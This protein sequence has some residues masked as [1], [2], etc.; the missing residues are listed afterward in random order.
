MKIS[1]T[2][3]SIIN[4]ITTFVMGIRMSFYPETIDNWYIRTIGVI[5]FLLFIEYCLKFYINY[6]KSKNNDI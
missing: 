6:L 3:I 2:I 5:F 1:N 4:I